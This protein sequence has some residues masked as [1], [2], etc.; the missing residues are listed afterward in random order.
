VVEYNGKADFG[1]LN[2]TLELHS[3]DPDQPIIT[4]PVSG[5]VR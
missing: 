5:T 4:V 3:D 2:A 1:A